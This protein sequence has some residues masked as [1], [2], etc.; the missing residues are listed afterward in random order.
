MLIVKQKSLK[1]NTLKNEIFLGSKNLSAHYQHLSH[2]GFSILYLIAGAMQ[3]EKMRIQS[4]VPGRVISR[5]N[6]LP[7]HSLHGY[8]RNSQCFT[9]FVYHLLCS[10]QWVLGFPCV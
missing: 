6:F 9:G 10:F 8:R 7:Q 2:F 3:E 5:T 4:G 1:E